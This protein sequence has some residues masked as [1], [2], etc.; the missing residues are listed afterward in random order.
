MKQIY[1]KF[2]PD[3]DDWDDDSFMEESLWEGLKEWENGQDDQDAWWN[4]EETF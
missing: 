3:E 4:Q 1:Q 2:W